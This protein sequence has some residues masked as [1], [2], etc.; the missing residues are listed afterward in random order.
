[1][2]GKIFFIFKIKECQ[3]ILPSNALSVLPSAARSG[4]M[5]IA[6]DYPNNPHIPDQIYDDSADSVKK[7]K[8]GDISL[9]ISHCY[10]LQRKE[11]QAKGVIESYA[12][13]PRL[14]E[15]VIEAID[16]ERDTYKGRASVPN[17]Y[18]IR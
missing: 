17:I 15:K 7:A 6:R 5:S 4:V 9:A 14:Q 18:P 3:G 13:S 8:D 11:E 16:S 10:D 1:M 2:T 12:D